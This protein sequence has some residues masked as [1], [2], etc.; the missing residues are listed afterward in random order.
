MDFDVRP[1]AGENGQDLLKYS[2]E[3]YDAFEQVLLGQNMTGFIGNA[4]PDKRYLNTRTGF[5]K[6]YANQ[7][8]AIGPWIYRDRQEGGI[9]VD[10]ETSYGPIPDDWLPAHGE[11]PQSVTRDNPQRTGY[12]TILKFV[13]PV[14]E[15]ALDK[16]MKTFVE[17]LKTSEC[18]QPR[19][20]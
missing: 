4:Q 16:L 11:F 2:K 14:E 15:G 12:E 18:Y 20:D 9:K 17:N 6:Y 5:L 3:L 13:P 8:K 7:K 10:R 1:K 19:N